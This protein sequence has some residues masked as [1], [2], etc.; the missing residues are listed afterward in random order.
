[1]ET[2]PR[3]IIQDTWNRLCDLDEN[4]STQLSKEFFKAQP[5]LGIY[6]AAQDENLGDQGEASPMVELTIAFWQAITRVAG[7]P[8]PIATPDEIES[9]EEATTKELET[10][11]EGS[12]MDLQTHALRIIE[13]HNQRELLSFGIRILMSRHAQDP[14]LASDSLGLEMIWLNTVVECLDKLDLNAPRRPEFELDF[15]EWPEPEISGPELSEPEPQKS[16]PLVSGPK[17]GRNDPCP[18]GSGKKYKKCCFGK[19]G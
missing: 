6:C 2:V 13:N 19:S 16:E 11:E 1:M 17:I 15:P 5:A 18:C 8:L 4:G 12:E 9:A 14:D 3:D 10:L 7:R